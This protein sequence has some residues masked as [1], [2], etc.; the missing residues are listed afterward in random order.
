MKSHVLVRHVPR[1]LRWTASLILALD[2]TTG[3]A[4]A[5]AKGTEAANS[6]VATTPVRLRRAESFLG[7]HFDFH[8][9]PDCTEIGKN[10][11][12]EMIERIL[13]RVRPDYVQID[14]KGHAG[15]SSYPTKVGNPAPGFVGDQLRLWREVT[16]ERG[17]SLFLHYSGVWDNEAVRLHPD[18]ARVGPDGKPDAQKTSVF[19]PYVDRLLVPQLRELAGDYGADGVWIDGECW[20]V[21]PDYSEAALREFR[22]ATGFTEVPRRA[23]DPRWF[24]FMQ[25]NREGFRRYARHYLSEL[26]ATH[27]RFEITSNWAFSD[28]MP[29][30]VTIDFDYLS[31]DYSPQNSVNSARFSARCLAAQGKPWDL[32]AW[33]FTGAQGDS[34]RSLKTVPQLQREAALVLSQGGGFQA[35]FQQK[36]DGSIRDW[37]MELMGPTA[38]FCR[39]RQEVCHRAETVPQIALLYSTAAHQRQSSSLFTPSGPGVQAMRGVLQ[40]LLD[41]RWSVDIRSEHHLHGRLHDYPVVVVPEWGYLDP[42]FRE[43][44]ARYAIEGGRL[45]LIGPKTAALFARELDAEISGEPVAKSGVFLGHDGWL[46]AMTSPT[47]KVRLGQRALP[48]GQ[49]FE[50]DDLR[51]PGV[52]AATVSLVG[53]G[54]IAATFLDLGQPYLKSRNATAQ[55]FLS[56][57]VRELLPRPVAE[58]KGPGAVELV[59]NRQPSRLLVQLVNVSGPHEDAAVQTIATVD[60]VG[61]FEVVVRPGT[62]PRRVRLEPGDRSVK[63]R[64]E[65]GE[66]RALVP[67]VDLHDILVL[68]GPAN[69]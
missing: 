7:I 39:A 48:F 42:E 6:S 10:T 44:L 51:T 57:L 27:P 2:L 40:S 9:G 21:V 16:A 1:V 36:R 41:S 55:G 31:G 33:A 37:H 65:R 18:W 8:A 62:R 50:S 14:C 13:T 30:P 45:L 68:E 15:F 64:W 60:P 47:A 58:V 66:V 26:K 25:F 19:G 17:V 43:E 46:S 11:T 22:Q 35:Y 69:L 32:M 67:R 23:S 20:A 59:L 61:P 28:H 38:E 56:D 53:N 12:R 52:P 24:E 4:G 3:S 49:L 34:V 29:E 5:A 63:W 54:M